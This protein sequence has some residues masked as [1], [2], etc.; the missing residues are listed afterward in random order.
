M[1]EAV[2]DHGLGGFKASGGIRTAEEAA[3]YLELADA[4][5]GPRLGD[6]A[7]VPL[8]RLQPARRPAA[9][10][11]GSRRWLSCPT[12]SAPSSKGPTTATSRRCSRRL[13]ALGR[14]LGRARG[15]GD[16]LLHPDHVAEVAQPRA[17]RARGDLDG[18]PRRPL[19]DRPHPRAGHAHDDRRRGLGGHRPAR[20]PL[21]GRAVPVPPGD[22]DRSTTSSRSRWA[23]CSCRSSIARP[24]RDASPRRSCTSTS[25]ARRPPRSCSGSP[26]ATAC[27]SPTA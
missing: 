9:R 15:R 3:Q 14:R 19:P 26:P 2:R 17:R 24:R 7:D 23:R 25:R 21:H 27:A 8:R 4:L 11:V 10:A 18:R 13:A 5:F 6:A 22:L 12:R 1:L 16:R 20:R